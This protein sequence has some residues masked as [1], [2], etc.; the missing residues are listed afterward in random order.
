MARPELVYMFAMSLDGF[1][2]REDGSVDWL[3]AF[4]ANADFDFDSFLASL[5]GIVMGRESY[6]VAR[7]HGGWEYGAL[8][9]VV[10][11]HRPVDDLPPNVRAMAGT[12]AELLEAVGAMGAEKRVWLFG[13]GSLVTQFVAAGLLDVVETGIIPVLLGRGLP[14]FGAP[15]ETWLDLEFARGLGNGAIHARYR[16]RGANPH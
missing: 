6:E 4:P 7:R 12:P 5:D 1:I 10:A 9:A 11:T 3:E 16:V 15:A 8:P 14:S 2:A 13:G